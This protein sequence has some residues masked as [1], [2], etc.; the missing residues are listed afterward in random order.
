MR[1]I[2][3]LFAML[4][5]GLGYWVGVQRTENRYERDHLQTQKD[6]FEIAD[7]LSEANRELE[8]YKDAQTQLVQDIEKDARA[9]SDAHRPG[10]SHSGLQRLQKRWGSA[11]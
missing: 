4:L 10:I 5:A 9:E 3:Y 1:Y 6:L 7:Q 11:D 2:P 8:A